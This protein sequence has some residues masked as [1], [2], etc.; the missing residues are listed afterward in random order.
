[1]AA[2]MAARPAVCA[3]A[4]ARA[5]T[6]SARSIARL[7]API[8]RSGMSLNVR[9]ARTSVAVR[10]EADGGMSIDEIKEKYHRISNKIPPLVTASTLPIVGLG[11]ICK[12]LTGHDLPGIL[13][14]IEYLS[15]VTLALGFHSFLP[16]AKEIA[17]GGDF[18]SEAV[19]NILKR[20]VDGNSTVERL[21]NFSKV[22]DAKSPLGEQ[23]ADIERKKKELEA[24]SP[25]ERAKREEVKAKLAAQVLKDAQD[26]YSKLDEQPDK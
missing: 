15:A 14:P 17:S 25:E 26:R 3:R 19:L 4:T 9:S 21:S 24:L 22:A 11:V 6:S 23:L 13:A 16:R 8:S 7:P 20:A 12:G 18:S 5:P 1:M 10:A 2:T